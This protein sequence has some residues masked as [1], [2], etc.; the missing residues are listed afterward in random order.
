MVEAINLY[1][2]HKS[3]VV[4]KSYNTI[5]TLSHKLQLNVTNGKQF[6][7]APK[8]L[9][10]NTHGPMILEDIEVLAALM[11]QSLPNSSTFKVRFSCR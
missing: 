4:V 10:L 1:H 11:M 2:R 7:F 3:F 9:A 8:P 5:L 6:T